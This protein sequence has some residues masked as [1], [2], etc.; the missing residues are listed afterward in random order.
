LSYKYEGGEY[1][2]LFMVDINLKVVHFN[3]FDG[4]GGAAKASYSLHKTLLALDVKSSLVVHRKSFENNTIIGLSPS[5]YKLFRQR[6]VPR[7]LSVIINLLYRPIEMWSLGFELANKVIDHQKVADADVISLS[8]VSWFLG[9]RSIGKL[10]DLGKPV[11]WT[12]YDMWSFTGGCHYSGECTGYE[13]G[14]GQCPQLRSGNANDI[15]SWVWKSKKKLWNTKALT[16]VC[17]SHWLARSTQKS[18]LF[19]GVRVE[20]IP[21]GVDVSLY[22]PME[23]QHCR[24]LLDLPMERKLILFVASKGFANKRKGGDLLE[25]ALYRLSE[26]YADSSVELVL[27]GQRQSFTGLEKIYNIHFRSFYDDESLAALYSACDVLV[28]PSRADN[29][30]LTVL[31]AMACGTP[32]VAF[33]I[34]G[35][36]E[37]IE[38]KKNGCLAKPFDCDSLAEGIYYILSNTDVESMSKRAVEKIHSGYTAEQEA[39]QYVSL[40]EELLAGV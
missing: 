37:V 9:L 6:I 27:L 24:E 19:S 40:Y 22:R 25:K 31:E 4:G 28:A 32:S 33:D 7:I 15:S 13:Q 34:G 39:K 29:L 5:K 23:R 30:P 20:V 36:S 38:D 10:L 35:M 18:A 2:D 3:T 8:W 16:L 14:C 12:L 17:P 21:S 11:V 1:F 26:K